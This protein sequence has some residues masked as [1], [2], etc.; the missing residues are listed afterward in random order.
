MEGEQDEGTGISRRSMV[1]VLW[2]PPPKVECA[3]VLVLVLVCV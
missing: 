1:V 2:S 3:Q